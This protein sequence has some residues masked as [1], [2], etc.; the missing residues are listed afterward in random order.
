MP[1]LSQLAFTQTE[2]CCS[3][4]SIVERCCVDE[5]QVIVCLGR[6]CFVSHVIPLCLRDEGNFKQ[7]ISRRFNATD[8]FRNIADIVQKIA[9]AL[10]FHNLQSSRLATA[11]E[12]FHKI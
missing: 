9:S 8:S 5:W 4:T 12:N 11:K 2:N 7:A 10:F 3:P 1:P 6:L